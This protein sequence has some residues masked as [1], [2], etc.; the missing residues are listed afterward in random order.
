VDIQDIQTRIFVGMRELNLAVNATWS[1][2]RIVQNV[3]SVCCHDNLNI[4]SCFEAI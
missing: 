4:L 1:E 2:K 3:N